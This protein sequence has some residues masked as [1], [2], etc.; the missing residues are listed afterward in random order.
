M[1]VVGV[2]L[3]LVKDALQGWSL[4]S[5]SSS[6]KNVFSL[7]VK[8]V[9]NYNHPT[10]RVQVSSLQKW[11]RVK[12]TRNISRKWIYIVNKL[13][14]W[15]LISVSSQKLNQT[16]ESHQ[17]IWMIWNRFVIK[18]TKLMKNWSNLLHLKIQTGLIHITLQ[19]GTMTRV[20]IH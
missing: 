15:N 19:Y 9:P 8:I 6:K 2:T 16:T 5:K 20:K 1:S 18:I 10:A 7:N 12:S 3:L 13:Q 11:I 17:G 14:N 4:N